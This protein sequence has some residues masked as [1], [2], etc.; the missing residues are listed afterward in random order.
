VHKSDY[1]DGLFIIADDVFMTEELF[2]IADDVFIEEELFPI[3]E[4]TM[5]EMVPEEAELPVLTAE[6]WDIPEDIC[7][8][9]ILELDMLMLLIDIEDELLPLWILKLEVTMR[10]FVERTSTRPVNSL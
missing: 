7:P 3:I 4:E 6:D 8:L 9:L 5:E 2:I 10:L 1:L